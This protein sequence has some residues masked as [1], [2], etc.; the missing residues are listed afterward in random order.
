MRGVVTR[1]SIPHQA[2]EQAAF[3]LQPGEV[4][5]VIESPLGY[6][7]LKRHPV[8]YRQ[9]RTIVT[10]FRTK[11]KTYAQKKINHAY[12]ALVK[13]VSFN[14]VVDSYSEEPAKEETEGFSPLIYRG[15]WIPVLEEKLFS[16]E[17]GEISKPLELKDG[18]PLQLRVFPSESHVHSQQR[19]CSRLRVNRRGIVAGIQ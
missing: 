18:E 5:T 17:I 14:D 6:H 10:L 8:E 7:V 2:L 3:A 15:T 13:L 1:G 11:G 19:D 12:T 4:S 16:M 9:A